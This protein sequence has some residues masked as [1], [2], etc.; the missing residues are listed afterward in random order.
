[1][2]ALESALESDCKE[3]CFLGVK[4]Y[5]NR[6][7]VEMDILKKNLAE[8]AMRAPGVSTT[9]AGDTASAEIPQD[10]LRFMLVGTHIHQVTGYSKVTGQYLF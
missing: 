6:Q 10:K 5:V 7:V 4:A 9:V 3:I 1:M 2:G 8:L